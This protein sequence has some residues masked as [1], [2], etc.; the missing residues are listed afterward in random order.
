MLGSNGTTEQINKVQNDPTVLFEDDSI[1]IVEKTAEL[2]STPA[3]DTTLPNVE[4][5]LHNKYPDIKGPM[6]VHRLDQSTSGI[7]I[8]AKN[9]SVFKT[10][11]QGFLDHSI[12][13][14]YHA[15]LDGTVS[16]E[17]G[18]IN[19][20]I[21]PNPDDRPRQ[22]VDRQYGKQSITRYKVIRR[23]NNRTLLALYPFTGRTHQLRLHCA[24]PFGLDIPMAGDRIYKI[25]SRSSQ[26]DNPS[27]LTNERLMLNAT[28]ISF[29]H[30]V[31]GKQMTFY[32][33]NNIY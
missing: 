16:S 30:P 27:S 2:L 19:L 24:S 29:P 22:I 13:K 20:P 4:T 11:Q 33:N 32:S 15:W 9:A 25:T 8:A 10:L 5:W 17:S 7:M 6:L 28:I 23:E 26:E 1:I 21:C 18:V 12:R 31:T 14:T 3:K